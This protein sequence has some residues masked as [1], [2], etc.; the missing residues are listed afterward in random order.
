MIVDHLLLKAHRSTRHHHCHLLVI[1]V[2]LRGIIN[3][4]GVL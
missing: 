3:D 2:P 4:R 1:T